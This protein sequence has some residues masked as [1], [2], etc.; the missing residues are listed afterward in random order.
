[1]IRD[2]LKPAALLLL[3]TLLLRGGVLWLAPEAL[4][5][6][7]DG[8][9]A[10]AEN[11]VAHG[12]FGNG[13]RPTA[14]RPPLYPC[15]L[16]ACLWAGP[17]SRVA[18]A[19]VHLGLGLGTV[20]ITYRLGKSW[21]LG[22]RS[23][24][25]AALVACDPILLVASTQLMTETLATF[26]A[27]AALLWL[28]RADQTG[29]RAS[30]AIAGVCIGLAILCRPT[31]LLW[32]FCLAPLVFIKPTIFIPK[33][34]PSNPLA[35][36][37][38]L[39]AGLLLVLAPWAARNQIQFGRPIV[40][41]THGGYTLLLA[42]NPDFYAYL[43]NAPWG[44]VWDSKPFDRVWA[45][46]LSHAM[47]TDEPRADQLAYADAVKNIREEPGIFLY[48][49]LIRLGR[50]FGVLPHQVTPEETTAKRLSRYAVAVWY[51]P[52]LGL[53]ALGIVVVVGRLLRRRSTPSQAGV[54]TASIDDTLYSS[55]GW[56]CALI[57]TGCFVATHA[58]FWSD[59]RMRAP[60][61]P[62]LALAA[63]VG[64]GAITKRRD[65]RNSGSASGLE[66]SSSS[67]TP[68]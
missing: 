6:D 51:V 33:N 54:G 5:I 11:L 12:T 46:R 26:L 16:A 8:Y 52:E 63:A 50:F 42:N 38:C 43:R 29:S 4:T 19:L 24:L 41:T 64:L 40:T 56:I 53:S 2:L 67:P 59:M 66:S 10:V 3:L 20:W 65:F 7:T 60:L 14:W 37:A 62:A 25:A 49:C 1:M 39:V 31:F 27:A 28:T 68:P 57:L 36:S 47:P 48:A 18:I 22:A 9:R 21:G 34:S 61:V 17:G 32:A 45:D 44:A 15:V 23:W 55:F 13:D 58:V 35:A 30:W